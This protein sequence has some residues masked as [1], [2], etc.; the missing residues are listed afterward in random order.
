MH[1]LDHHSGRPDKRIE[2]VEAAGVSL[3]GGGAG[4]SLTTN[5]ESSTCRDEKVSP[6]PIFLARPG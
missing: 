3:R 6:R 4:V 5:I 2:Q 1:T